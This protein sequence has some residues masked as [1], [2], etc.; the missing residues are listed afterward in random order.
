MRFGEELIKE[1]EKD[2]ETTKKAMAERQERINNWQ[3]DEDDCFMSIRMDTRGLGL[4]RDKIDLIRSGGTAWFTEYATL[5]GKLVDAHW[6]NTRYGTKLRA[7][8]PDGEVV[9]TSSYT[10][11]GL[12][13]RGLKAVQCKR[14]AWYKFHSS[15][16]GMLG[17]YTG[18]YILFPS[19]FNYATGEEASSDPIEIRD[20]E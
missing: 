20:A 19:D 14:P 12:A 8:M 3:T 10:K 16:S 11:K 15:H 4:C 18:E 2:I 13:K 1:L 6:C 5:D 17:A 7:V 9:W